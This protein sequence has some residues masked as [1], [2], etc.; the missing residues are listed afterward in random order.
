MRYTLFVAF[1]LGAVGSQALAQFLPQFPPDFPPQFPQPFPPVVEPS[2]V[3]GLWFMN[4]DPNKPCEIRQRDNRALFINEH[5][6]RAWGT[7][8]G[9]YVLIPDWSDG[10]GSDGVIGRVRGNRIIW[11]YGSFWARLP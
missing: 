10:H 1:V 9:Q 6:S 11:P 2:Y 5:G 4:G 3:Q 8:R 7:I